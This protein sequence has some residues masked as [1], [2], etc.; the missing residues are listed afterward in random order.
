MKPQGLVAQNI[1]I[2]SLQQLHNCYNNVKSE[3]QAKLISFQIKLVLKPM[4]GSRE[5]FLY[6]ALLSENI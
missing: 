6:E 4:L 1:L 3:V 5:G 2:E